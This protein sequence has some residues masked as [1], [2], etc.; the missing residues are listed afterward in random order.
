MA[1]WGVQAPW[2]PTDTFFESS[3][4][5][6]PPVRA[7]TVPA[8]SLDLVVPS[9][10][11]HFDLQWARFGR[12]AL[13]TLNCCSQRTSC[14]PRGG[15]SRR[16]SKGPMG[17]FG[18]NTVCRSGGPT[19][20]LRTPKTLRHH[21]RACTVFTVVLPKIPQAIFAAAGEA[22][23]SQARQESALLRSIESKQAARRH[24]HRGGGGRGRRAASSQ[25]PHAAAATTSYAAAAG[26]GSAQ[27]QPS[28]AAQQLWLR[29][30]HTG[31]LL[32]TLTCPRSPAA[33]ASNTPAPYTERNHGR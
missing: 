28:A 6:S 30:P 3:D 1:A 2:E 22:A 21:Q 32:S 27:P 12:S 14:A 25:P 31:G 8:V 10:T 11:H 5:I 19:E 20:L 15:C 18:S 17:P 16:I 26:A 9:G 24:R 23:S 29:P 13:Q 7:R 4:S 33:S